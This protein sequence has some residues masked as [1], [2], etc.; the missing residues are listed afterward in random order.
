VVIG[1]SIASGCDKKRRRTLE[2]AQQ[3]ATVR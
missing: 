3:L 1:R 2:N